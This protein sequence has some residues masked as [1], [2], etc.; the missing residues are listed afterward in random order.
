M[1]TINTITHTG[2]AV[3]AVVSVPFFLQESQASKLRH[4]LTTLESDVSHARE[5]RRG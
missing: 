4:A 1:S 2:A 3:L 5:A